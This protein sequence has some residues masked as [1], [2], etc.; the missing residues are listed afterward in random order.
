MS[1]VVTMGPQDTNYKGDRWYRTYR[2]TGA[3]QFEELRV[4]RSDV[5]KGDLM[6]GE[7]EYDGWAHVGQV[8]TSALSDPRTGTVSPARTRIGFGGMSWTSEPAD[9]VVTVRRRIG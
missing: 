3:V 2:T 9:D 6:C 8:T 5:R 7:I 4:P 1:S